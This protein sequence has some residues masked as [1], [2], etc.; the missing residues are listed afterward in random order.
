MTMLELQTFKK[1]V[2]STPLVS[3]DLIV[4]NDAGQVLLGYRNNRPAQ[5]FWFVP[6][7]RILK[8]ERFEVAF[9]R[10][11]EVELGKG[12]ALSQAEFLGPYEHL[13]QDNFSGENFS[14]HYV[15][16]GYK[17]IWNGALADLPSE[18]HC[19]YRWWD[20]AELLGSSDVHDNTKAYFVK[21]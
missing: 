18:Q 2:A 15:V 20:I 5:G 8:D 10:L 4:M 19:D 21:G 16:L 7:G 12:Y 11:T 17:I 3:M 14:T 1:V 6:G 13:Y 9:S